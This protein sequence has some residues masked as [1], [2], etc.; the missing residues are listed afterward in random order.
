MSYA[1]IAKCVNDNEF[2]QRVVA[3]FSQEGGNP[4]NM[5]N[6]L[7]WDVAGKSD[8]EQ[9]YGYAL[10]TANPSPGGDETVITDQMILS[11]VQEIMA[12]P[13]LPDVINPT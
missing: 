7:L 9:A 5:P 10:E 12:P 11:A 6:D 8:I 13:P 3:C 4:N 1:T 2:T